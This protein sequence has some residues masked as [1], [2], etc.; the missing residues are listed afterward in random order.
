[1]PANDSAVEHVETAQGHEGVDP[2]PTVPAQAPK[3]RPDLQLRDRPHAVQAILDQVERCSLGHRVNIERRGQRA[4]QRVKE[5]LPQ[6]DLVVAQF[7]GIRGKPAGHLHRER[8]EQYRVPDHG[9]VEKIRTQ[10]A[11]EV[12][13]QDDG[14]N[15]PERGQPPGSERGDGERNED[16]GDD[17][18]AVSQGGPHR[19]TPRSQHEAL[20][21]QRR[22]G[23][24]EHINHDAPTEIPHVR[25]RGRDER[26]EHVTHDDG[27]AGEGRDV[28]RL[29]D[30]E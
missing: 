2:L 19:T 29:G 6:P 18:R 28:G 3:Q 24:E 23:R 1:M 7:R 9:G 12:F 20:G 13:R 15:R 11:V 16:S 14:R 26:V 21:Q 5:V 8:D 27:H 30:G 4:R 22:S 25:E 17:G 10:S